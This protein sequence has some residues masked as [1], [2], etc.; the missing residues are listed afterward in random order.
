[1]S[2][3]PLDERGVEGRPGRDKGRPGDAPDVAGL[4]ATLATLRPDR[5]EWR[6]DI[7]A[8]AVVEVLSRKGGYLSVRELKTELQNVWVSKSTNALAVRNALADAAL[9]DLVHSSVHGRGE[10]RWAV[11]AAGKE[12]AQA[13]HRR[14]QRI[15]GDFQDEAARRLV[16]LLEEPMTEALLGQLTRRL[17]R[18]MVAAS[19]GVF[20]AVKVSG[21]PNELRT[22]RFGLL[23][24]TEELRREPGPPERAAA[25]VVL[26]TAAA[27]PDD[28]FG[29]ELLNLILRGQIL[30]GLVSRQDM[31]AGGALAGTTLVLDTNFLLMSVEKTARATFAEVLKASEAAGCRLLVHRDVLDEWA[32]IWERAD[33]DAPEALIQS[34]GPVARRLSSPVL[35]AYAAEHAE[36]KIRWAAFCARYRNIENWLVSAGATVKEDPPSGDVAELV[37]SELMRLGDETP[38]IFVRSEATAAVD[39]VSAGTVAE[40]RRAGPLTSGLPSAWFLSFDRR[41]RQAYAAVVPE[42]NTQLSVTPEAWLLFMASAG[43]S[44]TPPPG[45]VETLSESA[46]LNGFLQLSTGYA[47]QDLVQ[48]VGTLHVEDVDDALAGELLRAQVEASPEDPEQP[49]LRAAAM[50]RRRATSLRLTAEAEQRHAEDRTQAALDRAAVAEAELAHRTEVAAAPPTPA[51]APVPPPPPPP[52]PAEPGAP[53]DDERLRRA[54][55]TIGA[56]IGVGTLVLLLVVG[57]FT[58]GWTSLPLLIGYPLVVLALIEGARFVLSKATWAEFLLGSALALALLL[59]GV[60]LDSVWDNAEADRSREPAPIDAPLGP[61]TS[62]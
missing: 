60:Y 56:V 36:T 47:T 9:A 37:A 12:E 26:A 6:N 34:L 2:D 58:L 20:E 19:S 35:R 29:D 43:G 4:A 14:A 59:A 16:G 54:H 38:E 32:R 13:H 41:T 23:G 55:R 5:A 44:E 45:L 24:L 25:L 48:I 39:A 53:R 49:A 28:D 15:L 18:A 3:A 1:M 40:I 42:D 61:P 8:S 50:V 7:L 11:T 31:P 33:Q 10:E 17:L 27:D 57:G 30:H 51:P 21:N 22:V 46:V 62:S 52:S